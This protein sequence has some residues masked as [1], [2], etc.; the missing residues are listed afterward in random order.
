MYLKIDHKGFLSIRMKVVIAKQVVQSNEHTVGTVFGF[1]TIRHT[2]K[3]AW[4]PNWAY[5]S[6]FEVKTGTRFNSVKFFCNL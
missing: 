3:Q 2:F 6:N 5:F 1:L 4:T